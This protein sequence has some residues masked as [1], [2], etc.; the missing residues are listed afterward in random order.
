M[1]KDELFE[2]VVVQRHRLIVTLEE[3][4]E[5]EWDI[6]ALC[7]GWRVRDVV[8]HLVSILEVPLG[9]FL[10]NVAKARSF[11]RYADQVARRIGSRPIDQLLASYRVQVG[12]RFAPPVVGPIAPLTDVLV[13]TRDI[14]RPLGLPSALGA[15]ALR[16]SLG[17]VC[18][19]KARGFVP[20]ARTAGLRFQATDLDWSLGS[21]ALVKGPGDAILL[22]V[23][24]RRSALADLSGEGATTL[25][26]RLG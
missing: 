17:Y 12:K 2:A 11:D 22:A 1:T 3:L 18:G 13:H 14:E 4:S 5:P 16:T 19:G 24:A 21:G 7:E 23:T 25:A 6:P 10:W 20:P 8:G 9:T 15:D 26:Q